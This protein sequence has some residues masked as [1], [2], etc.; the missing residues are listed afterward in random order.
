VVLNAGKNLGPATIAGYDAQGGVLFE[1]PL[2]NGEKRVQLDRIQPTPGLGGHWP[3]EVFPTVEGF[4]VE[5]GIELKLE[6]GPQTP[7]Q[8]AAATFAETLGLKALFTRYPPGTAFNGLGA[9]G[10]IILDAN[11]T[12]TENVWSP[13]GHEIAHSS[14]LDSSLDIDDARAADLFELYKSTRRVDSDYFTYLEN[15]PEN[16]RREGLAFLVGEYL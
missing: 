9:P 5:T 7:D 13:A 14:G 4:H 16:H 6:P 12:L 8:Q 3:K 11:Q 15:H 10:A 2:N 1:K